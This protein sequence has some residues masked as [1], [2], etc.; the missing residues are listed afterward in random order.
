MK[1]KNTY[2]PAPKRTLKRRK[3]LKIVR[4]PFLGIAYA[5]PIVNLFVGGKAWSLIVLMC[6][7][8]IWTLILSPD[9]V[10]YNRLSQVVKSLAYC[11]LLLGMIDIFL[12]PGGWAL[13]VIPIVCFSGLILSG[14]LF[15]TDME[16]QKQNMHP[17]LMLIFLAIIGAV[18][19]LC[20]WHEN[21]RWAIVVMGA[22]ALAL[23]I[24]CIITLGPEFLRELKRRFHTK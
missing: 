19:G 7:Y 18:V 2:P 8:M 22:L 10:E 4:W 3:F 1:I 9:L 11:I 17:M 16:R 14:V 15:F 20:V 21:I 24:A 23:L 13:D 12:A 5:C 6:L